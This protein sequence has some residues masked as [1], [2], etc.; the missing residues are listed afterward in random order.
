[1][2]VNFFST[3]VRV[4]SLPNFT[5][6]SPDLGIDLVENER[7]RS[8]RRIGL[9]HARNLLAVIAAGT[10]QALEVRSRRVAELDAN[11]DR[12]AA[13]A[14]AAELRHRFARLPRH[15]DA[16][17]TRNDQNRTCLEVDGGRDP[18]DYLVEAR[19]RSVVLAVGQDD[20]DESAHSRDTPA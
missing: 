13:V 12:L 6:L 2:T 5:R 11:E 14:E 10:C 9:R 16:D 4:V 8:T 15:N 18:E 17:D 1:M 20:V 7:R 19:A 3:N